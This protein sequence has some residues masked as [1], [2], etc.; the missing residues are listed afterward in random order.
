MIHITVENVTYAMGKVYWRTR[1]QRNTEEWLKNYTH[2]NSRLKD[3]KQLY[4]VLRDELR[5]PYK[6]SDL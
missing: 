2:F 3:T 4:S 6:N 1:D 5:K